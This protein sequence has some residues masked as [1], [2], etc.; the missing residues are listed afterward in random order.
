[1]APFKLKNP[2]F[3]TNH[4]SLDK[5]F[6]VLEKKFLWENDLM[7]KIVLILLALI[8]PLYSAPD[9]NDPL[10][11]GARINEKELF[12]SFYDQE[13]DYSRFTARVTDKDKTG[14]ILKLWSRFKNTKF[15]RSGDRLYFRLASKDS[16]FCEAFIRSTEPDY[17][18]MYVK[19]FTPC[20]GQDY[21]RRGS[22]L[23]VK[24]VQLETRVRDAAYHR[25]LLLKKRQAYFKQLNGVN[26]F[27]WS[28]DQQKILEAA[29]YDKKIVELQQAKE[30]AL[31][32]LLVK[33]QDS[34]KLQK[35]LS[36][37]LD[38]LDKDLDFYRIDRDDDKINRWQM[39]M[40]LGLPVGRRPVRAAR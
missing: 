15:F 40:D 37:R 25:V 33:K 11:I 17:F 36:Y 10:L 18:I 27:I 30:R 24:S 8:S 4:D 9:D 13:F 35:E 20:Y 34:I 1:M 26:H 38:A 12:D 23:S 31:E 22:L 3:L 5:S 7:K 6:R 28:F 39:D 29:E 19:D 14:K 21:F 2:M 16:E 32:M